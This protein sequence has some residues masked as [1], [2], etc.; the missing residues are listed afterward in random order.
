MFQKYGSDKIRNI[1]IDRI[2]TTAAAY[3]KAILDLKK[4]NKFKEETKDER[5]DTI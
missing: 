1:L 5:L 4:Y 3:D 2:D